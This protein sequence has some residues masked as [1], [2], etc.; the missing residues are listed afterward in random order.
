MVKID[1]L[2]RH[3]DDGRTDTKPHV[4]VALLGRFK[5]ETGMHH[6]LIPLAAVTASGIQVRK[7]VDMLVAVC[8]KEQRTNGPAFCDHRGEV[9]SSRVI[10]GVILDSIQR[11]K[12]NCP[13]LV[14]PDV[15]VHD[16]YGISQSF[17]RGSNTRARNAGV[18]E[19]DIN[20]AHRWRDVERARGRKPA[21]NMSDH[22]LDIKQSLPPL[23]RYS[24]AL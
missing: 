13:E 9:L 22:Y 3:S 15:N 10:E 12:D 4:V 20:A 17:C 11:V 1:G 18:S 7:W 23:L 14:G 24:T 8:R 16:D 19:Q 6:H 2:L 5:T 21:M